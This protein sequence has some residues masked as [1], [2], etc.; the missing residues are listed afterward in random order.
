MEKFVRYIEGEVERL[1]ATF[2]QDPMILSDVLEREHKAG[3]RC[4][5]CLKDDPQNKKWETTAT[6]RVYMEG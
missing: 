1:Y 6:T 3:E 4:H 2:P 5:I